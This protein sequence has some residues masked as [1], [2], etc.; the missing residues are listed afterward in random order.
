MFVGG[1]SQGGQNHRRVCAGLSHPGMKAATKNEF[2]NRR[3]VAAAVE[4]V[5]V[6]LVQV[7]VVVVVVVVDVV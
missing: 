6:A 7:V 1:R 5:V 2:P 3:E 4:A